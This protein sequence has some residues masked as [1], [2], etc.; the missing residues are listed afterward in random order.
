MISRKTSTADQHLLHWRDRQQ[1]D[2]ALHDRQHRDQ[3]GKP[4]G[5]GFK[6]VYFVSSAVILAVNDSI[7]ASA[8]CKDITVTASTDLS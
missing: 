4:D 7:V 5:F 1:R 8:F 6:Q 2:I 3:D